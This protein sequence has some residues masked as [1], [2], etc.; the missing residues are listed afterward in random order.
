MA[1]SGRWWD[2]G[3]GFGAKGNEP[4]ANGPSGVYQ[5]D[6]AERLGKVAQQLAGT[7]IDLL[8]Q[9]A[10]IVGP[11][12]RSLEHLA[13]PHGLTAQGESVSQP[14]GAEQERGLRA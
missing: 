6:V 12:S 5:A 2:L 7:G 8:G 14:E 11:R 4:R 10:E 13:C 9:E 1:L 3:I